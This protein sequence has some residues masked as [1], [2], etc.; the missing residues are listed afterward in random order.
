MGL[1]PIPKNVAPRTKT[2]ICNALNTQENVLFLQGG[3]FVYPLKDHW[4]A[5]II[6]DLF[7]SS[8]LTVTSSITCHTRT[9]RTQG[10]C[11]TQ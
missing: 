8:C 11:P 10:E 3:S 9:S 4:G 6:L 5:D 1:G 2:K 7:H